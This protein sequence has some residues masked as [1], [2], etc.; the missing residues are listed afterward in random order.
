VAPEL[1]TGWT[2][3]P[4][5]EPAGPAAIEVRGTALS[6]APVAASRTVSVLSKSFPEERLDVAPGFVDPPAEAERRLAR[7][8]VRTA[9]IY[10]KRRAGPPVTGPFVS[11]VPGE[12]TAAFGARRLFNGRAR[13][14][15]PGI[16]L[17]AAVGTRVVASGAGVVALAEDLYFS[18]GTVILDHGGGLF[19]VYA[20]LSRIDVE[21][22]ARVDAGTLLGA[23]GATGRV[24]G[25]HLHWGAKIGE[26]A[27][28]PKA[29]LDPALFGPS[30][31]E[32]R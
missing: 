12:P 9:E 14:P 31:T 8:R 16:D 27:F 24:T 3:V 4:L 6:G 26:R 18:G 5:D 29:L 1:W 10:A 21:E 28:D 13:A 15:H 7:E 19:T 2:L 25:A 17:R 22:G 32:D 20:H 23:S 11:P 30:G